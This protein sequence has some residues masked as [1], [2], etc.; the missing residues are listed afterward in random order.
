MKFSINQMYGEDLGNSLF[1]NL[2]SN[3]SALFD[4]YV[5]VYGASCA[6]ES[7]ASQSSQPESQ[8]DSEAHGKPMSLTQAI[9]KKHKQDSRLGGR[10]K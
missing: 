6:S 7:I 10:K 2:Q 8:P 4:D 5:G 9:F 1:T 3:L